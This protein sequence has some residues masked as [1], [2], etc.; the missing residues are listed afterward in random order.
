MRYL[1]FLFLFFSATC[2]SGCS[3]K[4]Q[5]VMYFAPR[6]IEKACIFEEDILLNIDDQICRL[7]QVLS[8][9]SDFPDCEAPDTLL[10]TTTE[11]CVAVHA[12]GGTIYTATLFSAPMA[13]GLRVERTDK[14]FSSF[15]TIVETEA[16]DIS[17]ARISGDYCYYTVRGS[18]MGGHGYSMMR[19][20]LDENAEP[21][22]LWEDGGYDHYIYINAF[23]IYDHFLI[24]TVD[25]GQNQSLNIYDL[26]NG[27]WLIENDPSMAYAAYADGK[28][29]YKDPEN[30]EVKIYELKSSTVTSSF[31]LETDDNVCVSCD[32]DYIYIDYSDALDPGENQAH[33]KIYDYEGNVVEDIDLSEIVSPEDPAVQ[34]YHSAYMCSTKELLFIGKQTAP[35]TN[36][37]YVLEKSKIGTEKNLQIYTIH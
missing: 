20:A 23:H 13:T 25:Y 18:S 5:P 1:F 35:D 19:I 31:R 6:Q 2:F 3:S 8:N 14:T 16:Y 36:P 7:D 24:F 28:L 15:Q 33:L 11:Y 30:P 21:E 27:T 32:E 12:E 17:G 26:E 4:A 34:Q 29:V 22:L 10:G 37:I 9:I